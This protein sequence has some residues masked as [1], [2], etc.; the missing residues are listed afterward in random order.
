MLTYK[1]SDVDSNLQMS[2]EKLLL[3]QPFTDNHMIPVTSDHRTFDI[4]EYAKPGA[5]ILTE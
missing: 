5:V 4:S 3:I 1:S 2:D